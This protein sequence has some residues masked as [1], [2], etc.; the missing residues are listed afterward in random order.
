MEVSSCL[1]KSIRCKN[2]STLL[3]TSSSS[4]SL[5]R[6]PFL[7]DPRGLNALG[8]RLPRGALLPEQL[9]LRAF[10]PSAPTSD[11]PVFMG[12]KDCLRG[13]LSGG[14]RNWEEGLNGRVGLISARSFKQETSV[15]PSE[16]T[17]RLF[18]AGERLSTSDRLREDVSVA[19]SNTCGVL[20][21]RGNRGLSF[22]APSVGDVGS[23]KDNRLFMLVSTPASSFWSFF[24]SRSISLP[25]VPLWKSMESS[26]ILS[27]LSAIEF[28]NIVL[29]AYSVLWYAILLL[30]TVKSILLRFNLK[31][32]ETLCFFVVGSVQRWQLCKFSWVYARRFFFGVRTCSKINYLQNKTCHLIETINKSFYWPKAKMNWELYQALFSW[33]LRR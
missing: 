10:K 29:S 31:L 17:L 32:C 8:D 27:F 11:P 25:M 18:A 6:L 20:Y 1:L 3:A 5:T 15:F 2:L 30:L 14:S 12:G 28:I 19:D 13:W 23:G 26:W 24:F 7:G 16:D 33:K 4:P 21:L 22:L 9:P